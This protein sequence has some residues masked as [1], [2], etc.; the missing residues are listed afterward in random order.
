[1]KVCK[2]CLLP[3]TFPKAQIDAAGLCNYCRRGTTLVDYS[4]EEPRF[5]ALINEIQHGDQPRY[6]CLV[7]YSGGKDSSYV[8]I[9]MKKKY[10]LR[11]LAFTLDNGFVSEKAK[12]NMR[13]ICD[14]LGI[15][16]LTVKPD[17]EK[18][19]AVFKVALQHKIFAKNVISRV[20][21]ACYACIT[22]VNYKAIQL[23]I[24]KGLRI[25][26]SGFTH[27]QIPKAVFSINP[28]FLEETFKD[29]KKQLSEKLNF[30]VD[31]F[32]PKI[33]FL[34]LKKAPALY[35]VNPLLFGKYDE[36][37]IIQT[38][39]KYGWERPKDTDS[40]SSN[41][42]MNKVG[43]Y[44][45]YKMYG[46]HPYQYE[47]SSLIRIGSITAEEGKKILADILIDNKGRNIIKKLG[48]KE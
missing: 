15:D 30:D 1:M 8:L 20:S 33:D 13:H 23:A 47:I 3:Q 38:I 28:D 21:A 14:N 46:Y 22:F 35:N 27:G 17:P 5:K 24:E 9:Q 26:A 43:N 39:K 45:H 12:E 7:S 42:L 2:N 19:D 16:L 48:L 31:K 41:C 37:K 10:G 36:K 18:M 4:H 44:Y 11:P 29:M 25:I 34:K 32:Y 40:C 6:N